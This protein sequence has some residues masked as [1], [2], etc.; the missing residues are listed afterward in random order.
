MKNTHKLKKNI[1][2]LKNNTIEKWKKTGEK[3]RKHP[4]NV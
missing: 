4:K 3:H 2:N 1:E